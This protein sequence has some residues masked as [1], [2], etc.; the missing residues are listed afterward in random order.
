MWATSAIKKY[1]KM[2]II[3]INNHSLI[4]L[5][6]SGHSGRVTDRLQWTNFW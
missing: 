1:K 6:Q 3:Q 4:T 5:N 2:F